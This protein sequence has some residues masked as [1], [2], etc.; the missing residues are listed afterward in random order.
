MAK[1]AHPFSIES[2]LRDSHA[3]ENS[4]SCVKQSGKAL[5]LAETV[6]G[7]WIEV[8]LGELSHEFQIVTGFSGPV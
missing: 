4:P 7:K 8:L 6:T 3:L 2:I 1:A 5:V